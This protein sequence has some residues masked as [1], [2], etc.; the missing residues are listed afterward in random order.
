MRRIVIPYWKNGYVC[1]YISRRT[2]LKYLKAKL[3]EYN[4]NAPWGMQT[5]KAGEPL[6]I[7]EGAFDAL[8]YY[9]RG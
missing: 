1:Y 4:E 5:L 2:D 8:S 3:D 9:Q 6:Y 7:A